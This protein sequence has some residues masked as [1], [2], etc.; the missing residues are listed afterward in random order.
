M[1]RIPNPEEVA[2]NLLEFADFSSLVEHRPLS[3]VVEYVDAGIAELERCLSGEP[4]PLETVERC[5]ALLQV[6]II[7][8]LRDQ[9]LKTP[10]DEGEEILDVWKVLVKG[11]PF[12]N[13]IR[14]NLR[15]LVYYRNCV[16]LGREDALPAA[17]QKMA[18]RTARHVF[19]FVKTRCIREGRIAA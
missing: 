6:L 15:E 13:T 10:P 14:D 5:I 7:S 1:W 18:V 2:Y 17:P 9:G 11:E 4:P 16:V 3:A 8:Y 19:L 12:W